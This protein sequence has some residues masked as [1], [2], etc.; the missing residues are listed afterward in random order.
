VA[1]LYGTIADEQYSVR[2]LESDTFMA[3]LP[4][5]HRLAG[6]EQINLRDLAEDNFILPSHATGG[7][8]TEDILEECRHAGFLPQTGHEIS[9]ATV[10]S[11]L[12][13]VSAG[14]G[15]TLIPNGLRPMTREGVVF[16]RLAKTSI[17]LHLNLLWRPQN[18]STVLRNFLETIG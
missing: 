13:L 2:L 12:G 10:Q 11:T 15:V 8:T 3:A 17:T 4:H 18:I 16:R 9:T 5:D 14:L 7:A 1:L 6:S